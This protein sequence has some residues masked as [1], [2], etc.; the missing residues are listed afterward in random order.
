M[1]LEYIIAPHRLAT[2]PQLLLQ[3]RN[4]LPRPTQLVVQ[5]LF[6]SAMELA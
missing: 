2:I 4:D 1:K 3:I 6:F 5:T